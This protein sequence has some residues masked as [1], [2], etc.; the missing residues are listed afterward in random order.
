MSPSVSYSLN[1]HIHLS[2][3]S[4]ERIVLFN[5]S[6]FVSNSAV[7]ANK[8]HRMAP[9]NKIDSHVP[10]GDLHPTVERGQSSSIGSRIEAS[11]AMLMTDLVSNVS[12]GAATSTLSSIIETEG[13]P[14]PAPTFR[15]TSTSASSS[16]IHPP[17]FSL[18]H[19]IIN[20]VGRSGK[21]S[22]RTQ[23]SDSN[24]QRWPDQSSFEAFLSIQD[25]TWLAHPLDDSWL[26]KGPI[27]Q[28]NQEVPPWAVKEHVPTVKSVQAHGVSWPM[29]AAS[30]HSH[31]CS[32]GA[33][34]VS[35]LT[36]PDFTLQAFEYIEQ[37]EDPKYEGKRREIAQAEPATS[38]DLSDTATLNPL[39]LLPNYDRKGLATP[40]RV[41]NDPA[42]ARVCSTQKSTKPPS[43]Y[44]VLRPWIDIFGSYQDEVWGAQFLLEEAVGRKSLV[45]RDAA[46]EL[47]RGCPAKRRL[48]M[49]RRHLDYLA[50]W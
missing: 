9:L 25:M 28:I 18:D 29:N 27:D 14:F 42:N 34:V 1:S 40:Q 41:T 47:D 33:A 21:E 35:L 17:T 2:F 16:G 4:C 50:K 39:H 37:D 8:C 43:A 48:A 44:A 46:K 7:V 6:A 30:P 31:E 15:D 13:K 3:H 38:L 20:G 5:I 36:N 11:A 23:P 12:P 45:T 10:S 24:E 26:M 49:I 32:D 19:A 22:F